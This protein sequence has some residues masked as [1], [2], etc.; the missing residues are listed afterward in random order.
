MIKEESIKKLIEHVDYKNELENKISEAQKGSL[1]Y[2]L[3]NIISHI[4]TIKSFVQP[5]K[6]I[7]YNKLDG[8]SSFYVNKNDPKASF[9]FLSN[10]FELFGILPT[11]S[12]CGHKALFIHIDLLKFRL[13]NISNWFYYPLLDIDAFVSKYYKESDLIV[14]LC[15]E[16]VN[17]IPK[18]EKKIEDYINNLK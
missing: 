2:N 17:Q 6:I 8:Y 14:P 5:L 9:G 4:D 16:F 15:I 18:Y 12:N 13:I 11:S 10:L 3:S 1:K 7:D